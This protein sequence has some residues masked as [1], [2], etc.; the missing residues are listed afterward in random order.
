MKRKSRLKLLAALAAVAAVIAAACYTVFFQPQQTEEQPAVTEETASLDDLPQG[1]T[2]SGSV[3]FLTTEQTY[4]L[5][6]ELEEDDE[7]SEDEDTEEEDTGYLRIEKI[8]AAPGQRLEEGDAV[9]KL[10]EKSIESVRRKLQSAKNEAQIALT[11]AESAYEEEA[12]LAKQTYDS[13]VLNGEKAADEY[14]IS[15]AVLNG[16]IIEAYTKIDV[17]NGEIEALQAELEDVEKW[18][19]YDELREAYEEAK[20]EFE[21]CDENRLSKY[22]TLRD[23]Y[24]K[25]KEA[26]E[27]A[28]DERLHKSD[29]INA[30]NEEIGEWSL[31]VL[32]LQQKLERQTL[33]AEQSYENS[34]QEGELAQEIYQ[35]TTTELKEAAESAQSDL[36]DILTIMQE[37]E[38]FVG[39]GTVYAKGS[40]LITAVNYEEGDYLEEE[41]AMF[42]YV[43]SDNYTISID[44]SEEDIPYI[45]V[46][47]TVQISFT[48]Y[49]D[50]EYEGIIKEIDAEVS[51]NHATTVSYPVTVQIKG[52]TEK[53]YGG[54]TG[55][56]TFA[57][58]EG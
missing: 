36:D 13:S 37:F 56:V 44:V 28:R 39:D 29:D 49:P 20:E 51:D 57:V 22:I 50:E 40:G 9:L 11:E 35:Y 12:L 30:K 1:I 2:E 16:D 55:A 21:D 52:D 34:V 17:L 42:S 10:T 58:A 54:M 5:T 27:T 46:G 43:S 45:K 41:G 48:A 18:E 3:E 25:A 6:L 4:D 14:R 19:A 31:K 26:Y 7:D 53:L 33:D 8:Y 23:A 32:R 47:D 38:E 15:T 24:L